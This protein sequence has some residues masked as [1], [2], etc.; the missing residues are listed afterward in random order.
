[1]VDMIME[2]SVNECERIEK[3]PDGGVSLQL[4]KMVLGMEGLCRLRDQIWPQVYNVFTYP[5]WLLR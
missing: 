4:A 3:R 5:H 1:M 2:A